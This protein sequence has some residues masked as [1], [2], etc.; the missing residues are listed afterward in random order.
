MRASFPGTVTLAVDVGGTKVDAALVTGEG[1][2][3]D[4]S[5]HRAATTKAASDPAALGE[6]IDAVLRRAMSHPLAGGA[7]TVGIGSAG[8]VDRA[9][10]T[11]Q[12]VNLPASRGFAI[13]DHVRRATQLRDVAFV[14]DGQC[15]AAAEWWCG[16]VAGLENSVALVVSTGVGGGLIIDGN[17]V[18]GIT[19]NAGHLGQMLLA[20][21][22]TAGTTTVEE[23][24]SG[25]HVLRWAAGR[26]LER[27]SG[28]M[29]ASDYQRGHP[30]AIRAIHRSVHAIAHALTNLST[31]LDISVA[32]V[33]GGFSRVAPDY[34]ALV[35]A[36]VRELAPLEYARQLRVVPTSLGDDGPLLGAAYA[37]L[38]RLP[39]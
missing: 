33:G 38:S 8:P 36:R 27:T 18:V 7:R 21:P 35:Q 15:L 11:I 23:V 4:G 30:V 24:A 29:L 22:D 5:R 31:V 19:G 16:S 3:V 13:A 10:G 1:E 6:A 14:L 20:D 39:S 32:V 2:I 37:A 34:A 9:T 25:P 17:P 26:G 12:P 28:Q